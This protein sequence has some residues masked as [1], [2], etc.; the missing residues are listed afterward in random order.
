M[1]RAPSSDKREGTEDRGETRET[2]G[3]QTER[4]R[5]KGRSIAEWTTFAISLVILIGIVGLIT[6]LSFRGEERPPIITV[7]AQLEQVRREEGGYYLPVLIRNEGDSTVEDAMIQGEL[8]TGEGQPET[9]DLT[10][11]YLAAG[12]E[13]QGTMVFQEDPTQGELTTGVTSYKLP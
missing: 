10:I 11:T 1:S 13:V 9:V 5:D 2:S 8:V 12:E 6:W 7:E 4:T 3:Q